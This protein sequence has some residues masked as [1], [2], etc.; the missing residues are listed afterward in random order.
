L[1]KIYYSE[2]QTFREFKGNILPYLRKLLQN[3]RVRFKKTTDPSRSVRRRG[4]DDHG[5]LRPKHRWEER[6][7]SSFVEEQNSIE[8][9]RALADDTAAFLEGWFS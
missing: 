7:D 9:E 6:F 1:A 3:L 4:Y 2:L 5:T 8:A